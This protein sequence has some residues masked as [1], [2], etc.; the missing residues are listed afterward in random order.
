MNEGFTTGMP[1][2][3]KTQEHVPQGREHH[4]RLDDMTGMRKKELLFLPEGIAYLK[5]K[6]GDEMLISLGDI[7]GM[8]VGNEMLRRPGEPVAT[9]RKNVDD[10]F[11]LLT[12]VAGEIYGNDINL[13]PLEIAR[14]G[15]DEIIFATKK[16]DDRLGSV[17][18]R[19]NEEKEKLLVER[20]GR[21]SYEAAKLETNIKAQMKLITKEPRYL[22]LVEKGDIKGVDVWLH[23]QLGSVAASEQRTGELL[24]SLARLKMDSIPKEEWLVPLD[25]YRSSEK[26]IALQ[27]DPIQIRQS[28]MTGVAAADADVSWMKGHPGLQIPAGTRHDENAI[29]R[30]AEKYLEQAMNLEK[31]VR[32]IQEKERKLSSL[33]GH[34][35]Y[36]EEERL[37][38]E[39]VRLETIDPGTGAIRLDKSESKRLIDLVE[40]TADASGVEVTRLDIPYFGVYNNHHDYATA[41][42]MMKHP[43]PTFPQP[44]PQIPI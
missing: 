18:E 19:F 35:E 21:E 32:S 43:F 1:E 29:G 17:F 25:F 37:K 16:G 12:S 38:K 27:N 14:V 11:T 28:L 22:E 41:D 3:M 4:L 6:F 31:N 5:E 15:G 34:Q 33:R 26:N 10:C 42:E 7:A 2:Q 40:L 9:A 44:T 13:R 36:L 30:T 23:E 39:I 20:I 8:G 24:K